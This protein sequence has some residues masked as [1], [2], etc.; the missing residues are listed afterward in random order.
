MSK[1]LKT[2][3]VGGYLQCVAAHDAHTADVSVDASS[4]SD[5]VVKHS[6]LATT[7]IQDVLWGKLPAIQCQQYVQDATADGASHPDLQKLAAMGNYGMSPQ[8]FGTLCKV[9]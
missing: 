7:L 6:A 2:G 8:I 3:D 4:S 5:P 9:L 1:R